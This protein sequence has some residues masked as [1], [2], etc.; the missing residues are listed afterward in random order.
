[1]RVFGRV[2]RI[3]SLVLAIA[4]PGPA[5]A[6][7]WFEY[8][9]HEDRFSINFPA[10]PSVERIEYQPLEGP[11]VPARVYRAEQ[12]D[13]EFELTVVD[14][15]EEYSFSTWPFAYSGANAVQGSVAFAAAAMRQRGDVTYD[16]YDRLNLIPGQLLQITEPDGRRIFA[17][18]YVYD[19]RLYIME[20]S[21]PS[22]APPPAIF[23]TSL[24]ILDNEGTGIRYNQSA[25][26]TSGKLP[27][28]MQETQP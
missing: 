23:R 17:G 5:A 1:M 15:T 9:N 6:Q 13:Y 27:V 18:I 14:F 10:D 8:T 7:G 2:F 25:E 24:A 20:A 19:R 26:I 22:G 3:A 4:L 28:E 21:V 11:L 12:R 16:A